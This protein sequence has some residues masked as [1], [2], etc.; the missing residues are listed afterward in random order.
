MQRLGS[1]PPFLKKKECPEEQNGLPNNKISARRRISKLN[2][3]TKH[4]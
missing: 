4:I 1:L 3:P 2:Q